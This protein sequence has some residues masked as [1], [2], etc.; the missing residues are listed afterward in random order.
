LDF[1]IKVNVRVRVAS[2]SVLSIS[3][4]DKSSPEPSEPPE[5]LEPSRGV[6]WCC[7]PESEIPIVGRGDSDDEG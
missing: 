1:G 4:S 6:L 7:S 3:E 5:P 2:L